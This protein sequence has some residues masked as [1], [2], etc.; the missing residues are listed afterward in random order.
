MNYSTLSFKKDTFKRTLHSHSPHSGVVYPPLIVPNIHGNNYLVFRTTSFI[1]ERAGQ[2][3]ASNKQY[4]Q[5]HSGMESSLNEEASNVQ[6][7]S[8]LMRNPSTNTQIC[9]APLHS[10][11]RPGSGAERLREY[12]IL[13]KNRPRVILFNFHLWLMFRNYSFVTTVV[14]KLCCRTLIFNSGGT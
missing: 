1:M 4:L 5:N 6:R 3:S 8:Y 11:Y 7:V 2:S 12:V 10:V 13:Q 14:T 9:A